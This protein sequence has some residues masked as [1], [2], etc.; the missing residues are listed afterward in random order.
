ML[1][2]GYL[3]CGGYFGIVDS[4][5]DFLG[6]V[7]DLKFSQAVEGYLLY[8]EVRELSPHTIR[9]YGN[10][11]KRF[12]RFL[13]RDALVKKITRLEVQRFMVSLKDLKPKTRLNYHTGLAAL[14]TWLV[15]ERFVE[16]HLIRQVTPPVPDK[17]EV[18]PFSEDDIRLMLE[19]LKVSKGY[20]KNGE[21][22]TF[23]LP[24]AERNRMMLI[25]MLDTGLRASELCALT[26][27]DVDVRNRQIKVLGKGDKERVV[28]ISAKTAKAL[29]KFLS[30][31]DQAAKA[32]VWV[33]QNGK[34]IN[35]K[36]LMLML[37]RLQ[38]RSGV[39]NVHAHRFRHT[40]AIN[41][42]RN[43]GD[44]FTLQRILGHS[45]MSMVKRYLALAQ[46]DVAAAHR[47]ASPVAH[48][49]FI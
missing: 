6:V 33:G 35:R 21:R 42:L 47:V 26:M 14:W 23:R 38:E 8:A 24:L 1:C 2:G 41:Y 16:A 11:F 12:G 25:V 34:Q 17:I 31:R 40:F 48:F 10:T 13:G 36:T 4:T 27:Q 9:D 15:E 43:G 30:G 3:L 18:V 7:M 20:W 32:P 29:W 19:S 39:R 45:S 44:V 46:S 28:P 49:D 5:D 22:V 37:N